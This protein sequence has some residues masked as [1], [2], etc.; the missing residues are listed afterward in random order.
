M[1]AEAR[2]H[3]GSGVGQG[4]R[5]AGR[6]PS[7]RMKGARVALRRVPLGCAGWWEW[8][9]SSPGSRPGAEAGWS[10]PVVGTGGQ[11]QPLGWAGGARDAGG[12]GALRQ[13]VSQ[14]EGR[15]P[16]HGPHFPKD[17]C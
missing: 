14:E 9:C 5:E 15:S 4:S 16:L 1:E 8:G 10:L 11:G 17:T 2:G 13:P 3:K 6:L 7:S 12:R